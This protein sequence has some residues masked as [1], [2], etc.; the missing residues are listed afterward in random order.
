MQPNGPASSSEG[1]GE[2]RVRSSPCGSS[3]RVGL[4]AP[5]HSRRLGPA[6]C[7]GH[8]AKSASRAGSA[9]APLRRR[10]Y[11][12]PRGASGA[13][14]GERWHFHPL[15]AG[16]LSGG[17]GRSRP[18]GLG[19][20]SLH[21]VSGVRRSVRVRGRLTPCAAVAWLAVGR[22][23]P[24]LKHGPR[25]ATVARVVR[26]WKPVSMRN[27]SEGRDVWPAEARAVPARAAH[28][29]PIRCHAVAGF[30]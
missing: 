14:R 9:A 20:A 17:P 26:V 29:R 6:K 21:A 2:S 12:R 10:T 7:G 27:E 8:R 19:A 3:V 28:R 11:S 24:V 30:E 22:I 18:F 16:S 15:G 25:S 13:H 1:R 5:L 4:A 23:R